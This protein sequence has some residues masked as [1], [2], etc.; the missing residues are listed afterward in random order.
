MI[1]IN[2]SCFTIPAFRELQAEDEF[3]SNKIEL[4]KQKDLRTKGSGFS[5]KRNILM[6]SVQ[7]KDM[8]DYLV[9]CVPKAVVKPLLEASHGSLLCGHFGSNRYLA[10]M[11]RKD[12][13]PHMKDDIKE[14]HHSC[15]PCQYN[16]KYPVKYSM[17]FV[18]R[19]LYPMHIVHC[20][21]VVGLPRALDGS[22][23]ILLLYDAFSR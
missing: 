15:I 22:T 11:K 12:Y 17:G 4:I 9:I 3:C 20:D 2:E 6:R 21:L 8:Q 19:P 18:I 10:N 13:W 16:D 14:F 23:A 1:A 7:T 5:L